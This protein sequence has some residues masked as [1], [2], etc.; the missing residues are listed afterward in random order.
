MQDKR[1]GIRYIKIHFCIE[2]LE[3]SRVPKYKASALRGG[4]GEMLL[5]ANCIRNRQCE[6]CDFE[7]ECIV[8]RMMYSKMEIQP[9]FMS[10]GDSVGYVIECEDYHDTFAAG[11]QMQFQMLL[12]GK[13]IVY[14]NQFLNAFYALGQQGYGK[15][16]ARYVIRSISNTTGQPI[17]FG[18]DI[19]MEHYQ[20]KTV[21]DYVDYR[22][23]QMKK[24]FDG[25]LQLKFQ[26][27]LSIRIQGNLLEK[28]QTE[29]VINAL[30]RRMYILDCFEGI[31]SEQMEVAAGI[32]RELMQEYRSVRVKRYSNRKQ[33]KMALYGIEG[34]LMLAEVKEEWLPLFF[35]G[36]LIHIGK[37]TSFGFGRYRILT[38]KERE[39]NGK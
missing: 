9:A 35:V 36:E 15:E 19:Q 34:T 6:Q 18:N 33:E 24:S 31:A 27:P 11:E 16:H 37:Y 5:R 2:Y 30:R 26:S 4:M 12:F 13:T 21:A 14:F 7:T 39:E 28:F 32:P 25:N 23:E 1:F 29:A 8:R 38:Q 20:V 3:D 17:L 22:M 10:K